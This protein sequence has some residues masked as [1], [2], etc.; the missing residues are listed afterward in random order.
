MTLRQLEYL[1]AVAQTGSF[2]EA[3][4]RLHVSQ[5]TL[6]QQ[7]RALEAELGGELLE[8][9][10]RGIRTTA[11][12]AAFLGEA[13]AAVAAS[14]RARRAARAVLQREAGDLE[15][16][17]STA[18]F[19]VLSPVVRRFNECFPQ[20]TLRFNEHGRAAALRDSVARGAVD[21][22][23]GAA[24]LDWS[25]PLEEV[26]SYELLV[27]LPP[28]DRRAAGGR[29]SLELLAGERWVLLDAGH[30]LAPVTDELCAAAGFA[31]AVAVRAAHEVSAAQLAALGL[32]PALVPET[33][34]RALG[35][36]VGRPVAPAAIQTIAAFTR[37]SWSPL[38]TAFLQLARSRR[39]QS[40][41]L[42]VAA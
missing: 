16:A 2:T 34:A 18:A 23:I 40:T 19:G 41:E 39:C 33:A 8:R 42:A 12:G 29:V 22:G 38:A 26:G 10:P 11:A 35:E 28:G 17:I 6:S 31:P 4:S 20:V 1:L 24:P 25:G 13:R 36:G 37:S 9:L 32:G 7:I 21:L 5:P 3:A 14:E 15:I 30:E 27:V